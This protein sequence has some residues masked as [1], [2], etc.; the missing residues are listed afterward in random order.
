M[1]IVDTQRKKY[2]CVPAYFTSRRRNARAPNGSWL[3]E[4]KRT[5]IGYGREKQNLIV[6]SPHEFPK[7]DWF[8]MIALPVSDYDWL[9]A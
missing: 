6:Y 8:T 1:E 2:L 9:N 5:S 7:F 3:D 4:N